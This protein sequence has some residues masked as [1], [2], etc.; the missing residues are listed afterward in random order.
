M[1][2]SA[3]LGALALDPFT[4]AGIRELY[5]IRNHPTVRPFMA[6]PELIPYRK[7]AA[8]AREKLPGSQDLL[9]WLVRP[10][11]GSRAIGFTQLRLNA[12][13][14][15][16]EIGVV[17]REP[18]TH[19]IPAGFATAITLHLACDRLA[20]SRIDSYVIPDHRAAIQYNQAWGL[21]IVESDKPGMVKLSM[22]REACLA[23]ENYRKV[24]SRVI[25]RLVVTES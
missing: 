20:C 11:P 1:A 19:R 4:E 23:N 17:F 10:S 15:A 22:S 3:R 6:N 7:H 16:S 24:M 2:L 18:E 13:R 21:T 25:K 8:W 14:D 12:A 5:A 9:L